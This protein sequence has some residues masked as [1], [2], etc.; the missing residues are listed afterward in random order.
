MGPLRGRVSALGAR[1]VHAAVEG[2]AFVWTAEGARLA[3]ELAA[4]QG[5]RQTAVEGAASLVQAR[6]FSLWRSTKCMCLRRLPCLPAGPWSRVNVLPG[7]D[8][9]CK[10]RAERGPVVL[11]SQIRPGPDVHVA[12]EGDVRSSMSPY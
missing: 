4:L 12:T 11:H 2:A 7:P 9:V 3:S 1:T 6:G 8:Q 10:H 5:A